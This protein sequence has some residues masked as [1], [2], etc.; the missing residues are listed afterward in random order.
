MR[1][2]VGVGI[3]HH[4][5]L[6]EQLAVGTVVRIPAPE[7]VVPEDEAGAGEEGV[8]DVLAARGVPAR[9]DELAMARLDPAMTVVG[10]RSSGANT[11]PGRPTARARSLGRFVIVSSI[12]PSAASACTISASS[13]N[14]PVAHGL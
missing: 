2:E 4:G 7:D 9:D 14:V 1:D 10:W 6:G 3:Q 5:G 8:D 11:T 13:S 12:T